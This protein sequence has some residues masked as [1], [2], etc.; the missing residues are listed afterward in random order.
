MTDNIIDNPITLGLEKAIHSSSIRHQAILNNI[1][2]V[3]T[4]G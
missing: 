2:N 3:N 1:S 4:P